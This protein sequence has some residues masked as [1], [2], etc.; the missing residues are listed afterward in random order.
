MKELLLVIQENAASI[1]NYLD[2][3][4]PMLLSLANTSLQDIHDPIYVMFSLRII[5]TLADLPLNVVFKY[6]S[7]VTKGLIPVLDS[8]QRVIREYAARI[9][10]LWLMIHSLVCFYINKHTILIL[11]E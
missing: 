3:L 10:N 2:S 4:F 11:I 5:K 6:T 9:R 1:M 8:K 7:Q